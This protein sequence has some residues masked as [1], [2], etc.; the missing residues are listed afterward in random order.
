MA[1]IQEDMNVALYRRG[2][3]DGRNNPLHAMPHGVGPDLDVLEEV[4]VVGG[5]EGMGFYLLGYRQGIADANED[6]F[7]EEE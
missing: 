1:S 7:E 3:E 5:A 4:L 2:V 6:D